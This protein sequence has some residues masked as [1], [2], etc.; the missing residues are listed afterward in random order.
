[1]LNPATVAPVRFSNG[2]LWRI[3]FNKNILVVRDSTVHA[4]FYWTIGAFHAIQLG[5]ARGPLYSSWGLQ[6]KLS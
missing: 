3:H 1:M 4:R 6:Y 2:M 5:N